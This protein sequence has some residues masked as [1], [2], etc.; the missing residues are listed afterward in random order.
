MACNSVITS[1]FSNLQNK[2][3]LNIKLNRL[4]INLKIEE[5]KHREVY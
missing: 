4:F 3:N 5:E 2:E 1:T